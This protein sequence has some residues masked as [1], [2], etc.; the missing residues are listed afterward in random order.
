M[1]FINYFKSMTFRVFDIVRPACYH[2]NTNG[3]N[4]MKGATCMYSS[5]ANYNYYTRQLQGPELF[6]TVL[7]GIAV[8]VLMIAAEWRLF[9]KAD[10]AGWK[11]LIPIYG[12]FVWFR[13]IWSTSAL[14]LMIVLYLIAMLLTTM[15]SNALWLSVIAMIIGIIMIVMAIMS[16]YYTA[17]SYGKGGGFAVGLILLPVIF[18]PI[19]AFG[20]S[21]YIGPKG[22][23]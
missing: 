16:S 18:Y 4:K 3:K 14:C 8:I 1:G 7:L 11:C 21:E 12:Q 23:P 5:F 13:I 10:E 15:M 22:Q 9:T 20:D 17:K 19:L 6:I 2:E